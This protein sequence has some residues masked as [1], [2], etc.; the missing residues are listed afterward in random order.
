MR[1]LLFAAKN[2]RRAR[3]IPALLGLGLLFAAQIHPNLPPTMPLERTLRASRWRQRV[4]LVAAPT[5]ADPDFRAQTALLATDAAALPAR[6]VR[7]INLLAD[8]LPAADQQL[9]AR[10]FRLSPGQ[11]AV[12]LLGKDGGVKLRRARPVAGAELAALIDQMPM[13]QQEMRRAGPR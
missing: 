4:L 10:Q 11:F 13:R 8:E 3:L 7:V 12:L 1:R 2:R 5:A 9:L 6:D